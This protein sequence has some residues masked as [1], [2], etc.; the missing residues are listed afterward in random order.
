MIGHA[1]LMLILQTRNKSGIE[2][3]RATHAFGRQQ[4]SRERP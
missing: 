4:I 1:A 2:H 3:T